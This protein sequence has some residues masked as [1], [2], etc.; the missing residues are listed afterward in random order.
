ML[1]S[2]SYFYDPRYCIL[3][4]F[5]GSASFKIINDDFYMGEYTQYEFKDTVSVLMLEIL[6][7]KI[8]YPTLST[9]GNSM[10][11]LSWLYYVIVKSYVKTV[12]PSFLASESQ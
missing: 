12:N 7:T 3:D 11:V 2:N 9:M 6:I 10:V 5:K 1:A 8:S 4:G